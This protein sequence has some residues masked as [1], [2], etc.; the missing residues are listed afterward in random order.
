MK[1]KLK[2]AWQWCADV[3]TE[4]GLK[5]LAGWWDGEDREMREADEAARQRSAWEFEQ[6][7]NAGRLEAEGRAA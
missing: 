6:K 3:A 4:I 1:E 5:V 7:Q 2:A